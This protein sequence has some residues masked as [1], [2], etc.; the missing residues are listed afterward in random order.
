MQNNLQIK[1]IPL[2]RL[3]PY[4]NNAKIHT[5]EQIK[6]IIQSIKD[7]GFNDPIACDEKGIIIEGH[8]RYEAAKKMGMQTIPTIILKGLTPAQKKAYILAHNKLTMDTGF[9]IEIL[10]AELCSIEDG[11][12]DMSTFGFDI[13]ISVDEAAIPEEKQTYSHLSDK[14]I[15]PPIAVF[16]MKQGYWRK[17]TNEWENNFGLKS[18]VVDPKKNVHG[19]VKFKQ[20]SMSKTSIF[21]PTLAEV[22]YK[23]FCPK[24]G[25]IIDPFAGAAVRGI[26]ATKLGFKYTGIDLK[27]EQIVANKKQAKE[28]DLRPK[29]FC[30][31][32]LNVDKYIADETADMVFTCPPYFNL[33][34]YSDDEND[35]SNMD[36]EEF[37]RVYFKILCRF[38]KKLKQDRFFVIVVGDVRDENG[39]YR[40]LVDYTKKCLFKCGLHFYNDIVLLQPLG[41]APVRAAGVFNSYRKLLKLHENVL[42]FYKGDP[43]SI[44]GNFDDFEVEDLLKDVEVQEE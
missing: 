12:L 39:F 7:F 5:K 19:K 2:K 38:A 14:Y 8:G 20:T 4:K 6:K 21:D 3:K 32:S 15:I 11:G 16:D 22:C 18:K 28:L 40:G 34:V 30:D 25:K 23:F 35:L 42:C 27:R 29:W 44:K 26:V 1:Q 36:Y 43:K 37:K 31:D 9:D 33:E 17:R 41:T 24:N 10:T 13:D